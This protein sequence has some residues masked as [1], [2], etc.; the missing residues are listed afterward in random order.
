M[1]KYDIGEFVLYGLT[2]S[3]Q[4]VDIGPVDFGDP[5]K[6]YYHLKPVSDMKST[7]FVSMKR[8]DDII[9]RVISA[10]EANKILGE[11]KK[12]GKALYTPKREACDIIIKSG[13]DVAISQ[14]IKL[15]RYMRRE[16]RKIHK[17]L[18]I[19]EE[20]ILKDAER[21]FF[22]EMATALSMS[23]EEVVAKVGET[24]DI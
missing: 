18:N 9:R 24:L 11:V 3:C 1:A 7:I 19:M 23:M 8:E 6:I 15:L 20:K 4:V 17:S 5:D 12:V 2:G 22:S 14:M 10:E 16:N 21:V 13:D